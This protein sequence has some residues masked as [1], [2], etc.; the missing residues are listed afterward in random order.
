MSYKEWAEETA[1]EL[2]TAQSTIAQ[3]RLQLAER[4]EQL[5]VT[6]RNGYQTNHNLCQQQ[7]AE[8]QRELQEANHATNAQTEKA[9]R[10]EA[11][12]Q[13]A[14]SKLGK[15]E[16]G[17][18]DEI[19]DL[20]DQLAGKGGSQQ[21]TDLLNKLHE[22]QK[23][24]DAQARSTARAHELTENINKKLSKVEKENQTEIQA[25]KSKLAG[26]NEQLRLAQVARA[27]DQAPNDREKKL[28]EQIDKINSELK[29]LKAENGRLK[30]FNESLQKQLQ[31]EKKENADR[32]AFMKSDATKG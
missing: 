16:E 8:L 7:I 14:L 10:A 6:T 4:N 15:V 11:Q 21:V 22:A 18:Q 2:T 20:N 28:K 19:K 5:A 31:V 27:S 26:K 17:Y 23:E 9:A 25:L 13:N 24:K 29:T 32:L 12:F 30:L 3:L 1:K